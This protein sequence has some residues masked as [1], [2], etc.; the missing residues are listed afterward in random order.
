MQVEQ[1]VPLCLCKIS[2]EMVVPLCYTV[3]SERNDVT[4]EVKQMKLTHFHRTHYIYEADNIPDH[5][6]RRFG[7]CPSLMARQWNAALQTKSRD[8]CC[9][10]RHGERKTH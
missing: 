9:N 10:I 6:S 4:K 7:C 5:R 8:R 3:D 1:M 2:I